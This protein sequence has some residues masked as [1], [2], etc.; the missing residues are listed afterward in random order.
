MKI[1]NPT[2]MWFSTK[3]TEKSDEQQEEVMELTKED[4]LKTIDI[5]PVANVSN[6]ENTQIMKETNVIADRLDFIY[7][8]IKSALGVT[9]EVEVEESANS[10][11]DAPAEE[12]VSE[13]TE[14]ESQEQD[15]QPKNESEENEPSEE[16]TVET[17]EEQQEEVVE[18]QLAEEVQEGQEEPEETVEEEP[19]QE[20]QQEEEEIVEEEV[21]EENSVAVENNTSKIKVP[22]IKDVEEDKTSALLQEIENLKAEKEAKEIELEKMSLAKEVEKDFYGVPGKV[23][24][25]VN[26]IFEIKNSALSED[27]KSFI[28]TSLKSLSVQNLSDCEEIGHDQEVIVDEKTEME[29]KIKN[30]IK[31]HGLTENQAFLFVNGDRTLAEAKKASAKVRARRK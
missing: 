4:V 13:E 30:A 3:N 2:M 10:E 1:F 15:E 25:K 23:E 21:A 6:K 27:T 31:E 8:T 5:A 17:E 7:N 26:T 9:N 29:T 16:E 11:L 20:E 24:D 22:E 28:L 14:V 19:E 18:E 12:N